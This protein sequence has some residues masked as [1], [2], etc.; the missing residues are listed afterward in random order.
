[1]DAN[2]VEILNE[3]KKLRDE[4]DKYRAN[5]Q[6]TFSPSKDIRAE[7]KTQINTEFQKLK[8]ENEKLKEYGGK[9][10]HLHLFRSI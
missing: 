1:M 7:N 8:K 3:N 5:K 2:A 10:N 9:K 4:L 6:R